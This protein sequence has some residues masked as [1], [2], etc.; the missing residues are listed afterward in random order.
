[1]RQFAA[2]SATGCNT[3]VSWLANITLTRQAGIPSGSCGLEPACTVATIPLESSAGKLE[4]VPSSD[5]RIAL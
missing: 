2:N 4:T 5:G 3:P 1:M